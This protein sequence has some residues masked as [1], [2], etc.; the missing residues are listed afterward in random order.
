VCRSRGLTGDQGV[1]I[2]RSNVQHLMLREDVVAAVKA[3][4]FGVHAVSTIDEGIEMLTGVKAGE[5]NGEGRYPVGTINRAVEDRLKT[6][7]ER[8]RAFARGKG[9][10]E[11]SR[12]GRE[13][14]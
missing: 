13:E 14:S 3:N 1:L 11:S 10:G 12:D 6:F 4:Q 9:N 5:R 8:G 7:A 2:P